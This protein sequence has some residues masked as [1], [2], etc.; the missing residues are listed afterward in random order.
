MEARCAHSQDHRARQKRGILREERDD[1]GTGE[2][3]II[4]VRVLQN[5]AVDSGLYVQCLWVRDLGLCRDDRSER[6]ESI[7]T[8][9]KAPLATSQVCGA[10]IEIS[11]SSRQWH[12]AVQ[13]RSHKTS[14]DREV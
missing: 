10:N 6:S 5:F 4:R 9:A 2:D 11:K 13:S 1:L 3:H 8:F 14:K 7:E 12:L